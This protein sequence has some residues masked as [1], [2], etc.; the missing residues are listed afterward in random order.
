MDT[1]PARAHWRKSTR[2]TDQGN[3]VEV[4]N[5]EHVIG[6]GAV[7]VRDSKDVTGP[8]LVVGASDWIAFTAGLQR[9]S[10]T[11]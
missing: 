9:G 8:V 5:F 3:C 10:I 1:D 4:A 7:G 11:A 6:G 2:S